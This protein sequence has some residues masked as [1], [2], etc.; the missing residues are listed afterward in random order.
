MVDAL[1]GNWHCIAP[2]WRG[3]GLSD[4]SGTDTYWFA[5]YVADLDALLEH[6][7]PQEKVH[8][9]GHSMGANVVM[10]YAGVRPE[11]V[12]SVA[13]LEGF[14]LPQAE[15]AQAPLRMRKWLDELREAPQLR[16]YDTLEQVQQRLQKNNPRLSDARAAFLAQHWARQ[17]AGGQW[18]ILGD[19]V[20]KRNGP[21][22]Y[23]ADQVLATWQNISAPVL[24]LEGAQTDILKWFGPPDVARAEIS[25]RMAAIACVQQH[26]VADAG[27][28]LHHD[29]PLQLA[30]LLENFLQEIAQ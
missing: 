27:H 8:L 4:N 28:M 30:A 12:A 14:G 25:R 29:Q 7:A 20:H 26:I 9:V 2:D 6:Y 13:N 18:E 16:S 17:N 24:W 19:P 3:F 5:D 11:R 22:L 10:L 15:P 1:Q 23:Q 21:L